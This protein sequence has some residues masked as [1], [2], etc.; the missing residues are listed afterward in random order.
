MVSNFPKKSPNNWATF[1]SRICRRE[2]TKIA[3]SG[4][5][6]CSCILASKKKQTKTCFQQL[7]AF[8]DVLN[9]SAAQLSELFVSSVTGLLDI[10]AK[11]LAICNI[12]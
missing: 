8:V 1:V 10:F 4:H 3:H 7:N 5:T 6:G 9:G 11:N 12:Q 2:V